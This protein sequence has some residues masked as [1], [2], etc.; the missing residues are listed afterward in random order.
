MTVYV[1]VK[2]EKG[3]NI[4]RTEESPGWMGKP[5]IVNGRVPYKSRRQ[6]LLSARLLAG[7]QGK[8][9]VQ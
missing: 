4:E 3:W 7:R 9:L 6:A 8:V 1:V 5:T 2:G